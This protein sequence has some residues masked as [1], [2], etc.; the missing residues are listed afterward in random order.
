MNRI[1]PSFLVGV[2]LVAFSGTVLA[3]ETIPVQGFLT[4]AQGSALTASVEIT[5]SLYEQDSGGDFIWQE[6]LPVEV[7]NGLFNVYLGNTVALDLSLFKDHQELWLGIQ[8]ADDEEMNRVYLGNVP[9][10][11]Y[12]RHTDADP[13]PAIPAGF[14]MFSFNQ[15]D[16]PAGWTKNVAHA[17]RALW[18][19][20]DSPGQT[21]G[22]A[23]HSHG[24]DSLSVPDHTHTTTGHALTI[25]EMPAHS[26]E[27]T[28][29]RQ[30]FWN[31]ND[32]DTTDALVQESW[33]NTGSTGGGLP[34]NHGNTGA[35]GA[36]S[37]TGSTADADSLPPYVQVVVCCKS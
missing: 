2:V 7:D 32:P 34:H 15:S 35:A 20:A 28:G 27:Y 12:A 36:A 5:F 22:S 33:M 31:G 24:I 21:G 23:T 19:A 26:H 4:D 10:A 17:D 30:D 13:A 6:T 1:I 11:A 8:V 9:F 37:L 16:C 3:A 18:I 14:C 25:Q 29:V